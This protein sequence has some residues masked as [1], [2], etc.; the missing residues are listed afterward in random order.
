[1]TVEAR[2]RK[3]QKK[4]LRQK[5][6]KAAEKAASES[7]ANFEDVEVAGIRA[8]PLIVDRVAAEQVLPPQALKGKTNELISQTEWTRQGSPQISTEPMGQALETDAEFEYGGSRV[9]QYSEGNETSLIDQRSEGPVY[10][11]FSGIQHEPIPQRALQS[12]EPASRLPEEAPISD[13]APE[14]SIVD[15][16]QATETSRRISEVSPLQAVNEQD[17]RCLSQENITKEEKSCEIKEQP[18]KEVLNVR[19]STNEVKNVNDINSNQGQHSSAADE[20]SERLNLSESTQL[21]SQA[22][23]KGEKNHKDKNS[24]EGEETNSK[25]LNGEGVDSSH[26]DPTLRKVVPQMGLRQKLIV[27]DECSD[28]RINETHESTSG[29]EV[30]SSQHCRNSDED[31]VTSE[32]KTTSSLPSEQ[33]P[34]ECSELPDES[35]ALSEKSTE[36][37]VKSIAPSEA[38]VVTQDASAQTFEEPTE[39]REVPA[40]APA[41][42]IGTAEEY[43]EIS[44]ESR[45]YPVASTSTLEESQGTPGESAKYAVESQAQ[46]E[47]SPELSGKFP[48]RTEKEDLVRADDRTESLLLKEKDDIVPVEMAS[49]ASSSEASK[50]SQ[51]ESGSFEKLEAQSVFKKDISSNEL[52][53]AEKTIQEEVSSNHSA[54][55]ELS[56]DENQSCL[57][58]GNLDDKRDHEQIHEDAHTS[59][60]EVIP[61]GATGSKRT[62]VNIAGQESQSNLKTEEQTQNSFVEEYPPK[63]KSDRE[64][65]AC[66]DALFDEDKGAK[67]EPLPWEASEHVQESLNQ[68]ISESS[69]SVKPENEESKQLSLSDRME[70]PPKSDHDVAVSISNIEGGQPSP[71]TPETIPLPAESEDSKVI[72]KPQFVNESDLDAAGSIVDNQS[73][74]VEPEDQVDQLFG[75]VGNQESVQMPWEA[76]ESSSNAG[77]GQVSKQDETK[78]LS[79]TTAQVESLF[80]E[81]Q[82]EPMP[83][84]ES[85]VRE[86]N[87]AITSASDENG[88]KGSNVATKKFSFLDNDDDL[89]DDDDSYLES[90]EDIEEIE[91]VEEVEEV[92]E[93]EENEKNEHMRTVESELVEVTPK[94]VG[95]PQGVGKTMVVPFN[96]STDSQGATSKYKPSNVPQAQSSFLHPRSYEAGVPPQVIQNNLSHSSA[97]SQQPVFASQQR[98]ILEGEKVVQKINEEKKKSDAFDFPMDLVSKKTDHVPAKPVGASRF[99]SPPPFDLPGQAPPRSSRT[100][101][102]ASL[103][104]NPYAT[105]ATTSKNKVQPPLPPQGV[106]LPQNALP[107]GNKLPAPPTVPFPAGLQASVRSQHPLNLRTRGFSNISAEGS[108]SAGTIGS[109]PTPPHYPISPSYG[110][111][112]LGKPAENKYAPTSPSR[113]PIGN[114]AVDGVIGYT[115]PG[116][117]NTGPPGSGPAKTGLLGGGPYAAKNATQKL[118]VSPPFKHVIPSVPPA[119]PQILPHPSVHGKPTVNVTPNTP[120]EVY[121][122]GAGVFNNVIAGPPISARQKRSTSRSHA[123][124]NSSVYTPNQ[125]EFT[126][127]YAPTVHPHY[128][129]P[130]PPQMPMVTQNPLSS[131]NSYMASAPS[132]AAA[133]PES[134]QIPKPINNDA[135]LQHQFPLFSWSASEK[136]NYGIPIDNGQNAYIVGSSSSIQNFN[137]V[138]VET[139]LFKHNFL[140]AFP[141]PLSKNK[142]KKKDL[143]K[144]F[145][146][147]ADE[148]SKEEDSLNITVVSLLKLK[149][150]E[151][152]TFKDVSRILYNSDDLLLYLSQQPAVPSRQVPSAFKLDA[153]NQ[154]KISA[155][156]QTGGQNDALQ[157]ALDMKDFSMALLIGSLMGKEKWSE[158]VECYL[159][160]E[161]ELGAGDSGFLTNL[162]SL[163]FQVF[164]GSSKT[165]FQEF[166]VNDTKCK[167]A[168]EN[169]RMVVAAVLNNIATPVVAISSGVLEVPPVVVEFLVEY[170]VFLSQKGMKLPACIL[171]MIANLPLSSSPV[172]PDVDVKFESVGSPESL[173][174][175]LFSEVYEFCVSNPKP[176]PV[177]LPLK[178]YHVACLQERG[179]TTAASKYTDHL[180]S[181]LRTLPKKEPFA[182]KLTHQ[183]NDLTACIAGNSTGWLGKP[184]LSSVWGHLDKSFNKLIGGDDDALIKKSTEKKVFDGFTPVGSRNNSTVDLHQMPF[185]PYQGHSKK[186]SYGHSE[187]IIPL[188]PIGHSP[189]REPIPIENVYGGKSHPEPR[190]PR[191]SQVN[192]NQDSPNASQHNSSKPLSA[193]QPPPQLR[194]VHTMQPIGGVLP[195]FMRASSESLNAAADYQEKHTS[196]NRLQEIPTSVISEDTSS[197]K[198][199]APRYNSTPNLLRRSSAVSDT[200][201]AGKEGSVGTKKLADTPYGIAGE[202]LEETVEENDFA[203]RSLMK[204]SD[205]EIPGDGHQLLVRKPIL[206]AP[207]YLQGNES[208]P[209]STVATESSTD[210]DDMNNEAESTAA[211]SNRLPGTNAVIEHNMPLTMNQPTLGDQHSGETLSQN[212]KRLSE[213]SNDT[214]QTAPV[215][216]DNVLTIKAK[217]TDPGLGINMREKDALNSEEIHI[218]PPVSTPNPYTV[219]NTTRKTSSSKMSYLP[220]NISQVSASTADHSDISGM[221]VNGLGMFVEQSNVVSQAPAESSISSSSITNPK[222]SSLVSQESPLAINRADP[223]SRFDPIKVPEEI[224]TETF[225]PVIKKTPN[226]KAFTPLVVQPPETQYDDIVED[227]SE[228]EEDQE[229]IRKKEEEKIKAEEEERRESERREKEEKERREEERREEERREEEKRRK[230]KNDSQENSSTGWFGWLKKDPNEKKPIKAKLGNKKRNFYYDEKLKRWVNN[231]STEEEKEKLSTPPPPPPV[232]KR[233]DNGPKTKPRSGSLNAAP[234]AVTATIAPKNPITGEPL[235]SQ[236]LNVSRVGSQTPSLSPPIGNS[237]INLSGKKANGLDDLLNLTGSTSTTARRK[238]KPGRGYVNVMENK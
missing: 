115:A 189:I 160:H 192:L 185:V 32:D 139:I 106:V 168:L 234:K 68:N 144:W 94:N 131:I 2:K 7:I 124:S 159:A 222:A 174:S 137:L 200:S 9:R 72:K 110:H 136:V 120:A 212:E 221:N 103:P 98:T 164:I 134:S 42:S 117:R 48:E 226:M 207:P 208:S 169:W 75:V 26:A 151:N 135:L 109:V 218:I 16:K 141:G 107:P 176:F 74:M 228:D 227:E 128:Q 237:G 193:S 126:S 77:E 165:A 73:Q 70:R 28:N 119:A 57:Y 156:L 76:P 97:S 37:T 15:I 44:D 55:E 206:E 216:S 105:A 46:A 143:Q 146:D 215:Q 195:P 220:K 130:S 154:L 33:S 21:P 199:S 99:A 170:G 158:V 133:R 225:E 83:W 182:I 113:V 80:E 142:T 178:L 112:A 85:R 186:S 100:N 132:Q 172:T 233:M 229:A 23:N 34:V 13:V 65:D 238:K 153:N 81:E 211:S 163:I 92:D 11:I 191:T 201:S 40:K 56:D 35:I 111:V 173:E 86:D 71:D 219:R 157:L 150:T 5:E 6:K 118:P 60:E 198:R 8:D 49:K 59:P 45:R 114:P 231:N 187:G 24:S 145:D 194:R 51:E 58:G 161:I 43:A 217:T 54:L 84:E 95:N 167:W 96:S 162:F 82:H 179:L 18:K 171:F 101:S 166:Y 102:I 125:S 30:R 38:S 127:K 196:G 123:R 121:Q 62:S 181:I 91:E 213:K 147:Y 152:V 25:Q 175:V 140:K 224:S 104:S 116:P 129:N 148:F 93:K 12:I 64:V 3:N 67:R 4:K 232:V 36:T 177:L 122:P 202:Q 88:D 41:K 29:R 66:I 236:S 155:Y 138:N 79:G 205:C 149:L 10:T 90:E 214:L 223:T 188:Q 61:S 31:I 17:A 78:N 63:S 39:N 89:L 204:S 20:V 183:L 190:N 180:G 47:Q 27:E 52:Q 209:I 108:L 19:A 184:K 1:M 210:D 50:L 197:K 53:E 203:S 87:E 235:T 14:G 22:S 69:V 230:A